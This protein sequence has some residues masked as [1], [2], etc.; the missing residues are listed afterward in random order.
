VLVACRDIRAGDK[1][2]E[3]ANIPKAITLEHGEEGQASKARRMGTDRTDPF[4]DSRYIT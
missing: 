1:V 4:L 2:V 3:A